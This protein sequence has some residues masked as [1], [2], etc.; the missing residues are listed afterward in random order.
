M[1]A[2]AVLLRGQ[3]AKMNPFESKNPGESFEK[4]TQLFEDHIP[5][6]AEHGRSYNSVWGKSH[7]SNETTEFQQDH[8][9]TVPERQA[10]RLAKM[11]FKGMDPNHRAVKAVNNPTAK[12]QNAQTKKKWNKEL[13]KTSK[14]APEYYY[15]PESIQEKRTRR[16]K[17]AAC[18]SGG[19]V[20]VSGVSLA[21]Y[22]YM[23]PD[24]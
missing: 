23:F 2:R 16:M 12:V 7:H 18:I 15:A 22:N 14:E 13:T 11:M 19:T 10:A 24:A 1:R 3:F 21:I 6:K 17:A 5:F 4:F 9:G 8:F 20:A